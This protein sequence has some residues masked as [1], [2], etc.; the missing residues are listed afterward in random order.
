M[1][2]RALPLVFLAT[3]AWAAATEAATRPNILL[4]LAD[5]MGYGDLGCYGSPI[6]TP[7]LDQLAGQGMRF[8]DFYA[9]APNCS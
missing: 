2:A 6:K 8:T 7:N 3:L 1:K 5:D 9:G 4:L